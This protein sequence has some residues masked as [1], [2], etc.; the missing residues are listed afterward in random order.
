MILGN[1]TALNYGS[2]KTESVGFR[3]PILRHYA[4]CELSPLGR[5][6]SKCPTAAAFPN[7][8]PDSRP[9][10]EAGLF[11]VRPFLS[12]AH[13]SAN[14]YGTRN[15]LSGRGFLKAGGSVL[16]VC[17]V[18]RPKP[19]NQALDEIGVRALACRVGCAVSVEVRSGCAH[20]R[21]NTENAQQGVGAAVRRG[22]CQLG[23]AIV[24]ES[25]CH[26]QDP[27]RRDVKPRVKHTSQR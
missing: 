11:S 27:T 24:P 15:S 1:V 19:P 5:L 4:Q 6:G 26:G 23:D 13:D 22:R 9:A 20:Q 17:Y 3:F 8:A 16:E 25:R 12:R 2:A 21:G 18:G 7:I 10:P 14:Q